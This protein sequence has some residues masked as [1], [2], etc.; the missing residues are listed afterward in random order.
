MKRL[1]DSKWLADRLGVSLSSIQKLRAYTPE[2]RPTAV[3]VGR[4]V[5]YD[6]ETVEQWIINN[7][8]EGV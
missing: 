3:R 7:L 2:K 8:K 6:P 1:M 4:A 5:R